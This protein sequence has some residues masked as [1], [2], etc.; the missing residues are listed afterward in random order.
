[1]EKYTVIIPTKNSEETLKY[2]LQTC[3]QQNY[4][5][6]EILVSDNFSSDN[7]SDLIHS[8]NDARIKYIKTPRPLSMTENFEFALSNVKEGFIMFIGADDGLMPNAISYV[9]GIV[10]KYNAKAVSCQYAHYFW[11]N[12]PIAEKGKLTLYGLDLYKNEIEVRNSSEWLQKTL[13]FETAQYVCE[14]PNLYYGFVHYSIIEKSKKNNVYFKSIT[15]DAYSAMVTAINI[16]SYVFSYS[17]FS[18][19]GISG[20]SNGLSQMINGD[21][22]KDFVS[23]NV[24]PIHKDFVFSPAMEVILGEA[25]YQLKDNFPAECSAYKIDMKKMLMLA[26]FKSNDTTRK[27]VY[28]SALKMATLHKIEVRDIKITRAYKVNN[29]FRLFF[30]LGKDFCRKPNLYIGV[31]DTIKF[32]VHNVMDASLLLGFMLNFNKGFKIDTLSTRFLKKIS[33]RLLFRN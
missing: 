15:P 28:D 23:D 21:I 14:L 17:P 13:N 12:V 8:I 1:M 18:I 3:L 30:R 31:K 29:F 6:F 19:A 26:K 27:E 11:P 33:K 10:L 5:N 25:F 20:K 16:E 24:H 7:T 32:N 22:A 9:N 2:T 4:S